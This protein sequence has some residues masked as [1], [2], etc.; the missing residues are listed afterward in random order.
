MF[1]SLRD[2]IAFET[3]NTMRR[4]NISKVI[5]DVR[6][7]ELEYSLIGSHQAVLNLEALGVRDT[8]SIAVIYRN[9]PEQHEHASVA[10]SN[11]GIT[12]IRY[13]KDIQSGID[14]LLSR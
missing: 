7:A 11:R 8:D 9:N 6:D 5:W 10:A 12:N 4:E 14:W 1:E 2:N 13:F 3:V